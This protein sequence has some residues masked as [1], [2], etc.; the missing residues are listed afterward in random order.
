M[1]FCLSQERDR[2]GATNACPITCQGEKEKA[3]CGSD[4]NIYKNECEMKMLNCG[5][6]TSFHFINKVD[7]FVYI[8]LN[9]PLYSSIALCCRLQQKR[10]IIKVD[11]EKCRTKF[12]K[13]SKN[14]CT[15]E[16]DFVCGT[17]ANTYQNK[18]HLQTASCL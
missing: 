10:K 12:T 2:H 1:A 15:E 9:A 4:G 7:E 8:Y 11:F 13:C 17:D 6:V 3:I 16:E 14:I 18:C 5:Y